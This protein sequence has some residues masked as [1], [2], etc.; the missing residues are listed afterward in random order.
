[1]IDIS[2]AIDTVNRMALLEKIETTSIGSY[3]KTYIKHLLT[4]HM[5]TT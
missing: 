4:K 5:Q 1:M 2:K 3:T